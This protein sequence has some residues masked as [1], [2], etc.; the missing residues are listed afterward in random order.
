MTKSTIIPTRW[1][2]LIAIAI[3]LVTSFMLAIAPHT[4]AYAADDDNPANTPLAAAPLSLQTQAN[5]ATWYRLAGPIALDTMKS[6]TSNAAGF[7]RGDC[8]T[9]ILATANGY[10]DA[11]SASGLAGKYHCP[12]LLT[13]PDQLSSQTRSEI[14]R[15]GVKNI[16]ISGGPA[17]VSDSVDR[18]LKNE[19]GCTVSRM[20]GEDASGTALKT[21]EMG[22]KVGGGWGDTL[23]V[24]TVDGYW[25]A[26]S[27]AP[28]AYAKNAPIILADS[29]NNF[30]DVNELSND[31]LKALKGKK[32]K[33]VI[34]CG[35][36]AAVSSGVE[37]QVPFLFG[38][39]VEIVRL[40]GPTAD[41]T[42]A[43]IAKFCVDEGMSPERIGAATMDGYWDALSGASL[44]GKGN[45]PIVLVSDSSKGAIN[46]YVK[47]R[48]GTIQT[49]YVFGGPAAVSD[50]TYSAL[51]AATK[52]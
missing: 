9:V 12:V 18:T 28:Y 46:D 34:I 10:W 22:E 23:I 13:N 14:A 27:V 21:F 6:I 41:Y 30:T 43:K 17:A 8:T 20:Y 47:P 2:A 7:K 26:L 15:L 11:L 31:A 51:A 52:R 36:T 5:Q 4:T 29:P 39:S 19:M 40:S 37:A 50:S 44:C 48:A 33:R 42:S 35:G 3:T 49:G 32:F 1:H 45:F 16:I 38:D 25:D 24:A